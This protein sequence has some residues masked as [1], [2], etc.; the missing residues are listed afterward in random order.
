MSSCTNK[1][2][3]RAQHHHFTVRHIDDAHH[4]KGD[5]QTDCSQQQD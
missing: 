2:R 1:G 4:A 5:G 3:V